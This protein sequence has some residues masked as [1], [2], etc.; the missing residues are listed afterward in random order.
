M[1]ILEYLYP[2]I[3]DN[4]LEYYFDELIFHVTI[5]NSYGKGTVNVMPAYTFNRILNMLI[6]S[7]IKVIDR[8]K[9]TSFILKSISFSDMP[10]S[11]LI[12]IFSVSMFTST[13]EGIVEKLLFFKIKFAVTFDVLI[14]F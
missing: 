9:M 2:Y 13:E 5:Q 10:S 7:P 6:S 3:P 14:I 1:S 4:I 11:V 12:N 8:L